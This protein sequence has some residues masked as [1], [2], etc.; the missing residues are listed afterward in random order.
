MKQIGK[1]D[2]HVPTSYTYNVLVPVGLHCITA[3][4]DDDDDELAIQTIDA[5][6]R[7][8]TR[9]FVSRESRWLRLCE[10][11]V[12]NVPTLEFQILLVSRR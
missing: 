5:T 10:L 7:T 3:A 12:G 9:G 1:N 2:T 8:S 11:N 4:D 6:R